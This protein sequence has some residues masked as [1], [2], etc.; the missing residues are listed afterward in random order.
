MESGAKV[1][2]T[3]DIWSKPAEFSARATALKTE[4][5][6]LAGVAGGGDAAAIQ[7]QFRA[8][9]GACGACHEGFKIKS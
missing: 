1:A 9:R 2:T 4:A 7:A 8:V 5:H 6:K 3:A